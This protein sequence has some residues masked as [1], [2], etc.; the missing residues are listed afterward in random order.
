[1]VITSMPNCERHSFFRCWGVG[2][3]SI[4][5]SWGLLLLCCKLFF[6]SRS[7]SSKKVTK[8]DKAL[9]LMHW[10]IPM[11]DKT[12]T[13]HHRKNAAL[14]LGNWCHHPRVSPSPSFPI[15]SPS[16]KL[17][18]SPLVYLSVLRA[19]LLLCNRWGSYCNWKKQV[20]C[21]QE[22]LEFMHKLGFGRICVFRSCLAPRKNSGSRRSLPDKAY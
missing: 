8:T 15:P 18:S 19:S 6:V 14:P 22:P 5:V 17:W 21:V 13:P 20:F 3:F 11:I 9:D 10:K 2:R 4:M 16:L 7:H 12:P 1:M